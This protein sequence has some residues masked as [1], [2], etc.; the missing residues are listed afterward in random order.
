MSLVSQPDEE[1][2][3]PPRLVESETPRDATECR[4][5]LS[6][7]RRAVEGADSTATVL[8]VK[9][10]RARIVPAAATPRAPA[11][12][13][14]L[15]DDWAR[16]GGG[17]RR[18]RGG[19]LPNAWSCT[20]IALAFF[21]FAVLA[22][23]LVLSV[24]V[25]ELSD[26]VSAAWHRVQGRISEHQVDAAI[27]DGF[28]SVHNVFLATNAA[29]DTGVAIEQSADRV[30]AAV[31]ASAAVLERLNEVAARLADHPTVSLALGGGR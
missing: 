28:G 21:A 1:A 16:R 26:S 30:V 20:A 17:D 31:N 22:S 9:S 27:D 25:Y 7:A 10:A 23:Q 15:D 5:L 2:P 12:G 18:G 8:G 4:S 6:S 14:H 3:W 13:D 29:A 19:M 24:L 11:V